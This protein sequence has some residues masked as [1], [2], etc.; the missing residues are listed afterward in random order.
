MRN[1][2]ALCAT[3]V[4]VSACGTPTGPVNPTGTNGSTTGTTT[5]SSA[6]ASKQ[7]YIQALT[8]IKT[9]TTDAAVR[10]AI[11]TNL[12]VVAAIP[13]VAWASA[14]ASATT[15]LN[16]W[17]QAANGACGTVAASGSATGSAS[18]STGSSTSTGSNTGASAGVNVGVNVGG[19]ANGSTSGSTTGSTSGSASGSASGSTSGSTSGSATGSGDIYASQANYFAFLDCAGK[20]DSTALTMANLFKSQLQIYNEANWATQTKILVQATHKSFVD[21]YGAGCM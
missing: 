9:N 12:N 19:S 5:A 14:S 8:C 11:D 4:L 15:G 17:L 2:I 1:F 18:G 3:L 13:D 10:T 20:K 7:A 16:A 21:T 6:I